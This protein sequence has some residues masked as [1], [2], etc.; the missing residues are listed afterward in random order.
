MKLLLT[1]LN[2]KSPNMIDKSPRKEGN[3]PVWVEFEYHLKEEQQWHGYLL[4]WATCGTK[5][6]FG[7]PVYLCM[8]GKNNH[9]PRSCSCCSSK[10]VTLEAN[11]SEAKKETTEN[12]EEKK[13]QSS[14]SKREEKCSKIRRISEINSSNQQCIV[15]RPD[16]S[17][18]KSTSFVCTLF[19]LL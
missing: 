14:K 7:L 19:L 12:G 18:R 6:H 16:M 3:I 10:M 4:I 11:G 17:W 5:I 9:V 13:E 2:S 8:L 1:Y 15:Q